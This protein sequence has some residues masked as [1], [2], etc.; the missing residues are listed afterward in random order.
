MYLLASEQLFVFCPSGQYISHE[1]LR[2]YRG[3][4]KKPFQQTSD[5]KGNSMD[6]RSGKSLLGITVI[7]GLSI[8]AGCAGLASRLNSSQ[9]LQSSAPA[10]SASTPLNVSLD[11]YGGREDIKCATVTPYFHLEKINS[12]WYFCDPLGNGLISMSVGNITPNGNPTTDCNGTNTYPIYIAKYGDTTSNWGWQTL[13]RMVSWGFNSA[14]QDSTGWVLP[15]ETC[16]TCAWPSGKQPIPLPY[17]TEAK[18]AEYASINQFGYLTSPIKDELAGT[19]NNYHSWRGAALFDVFDPALNTEWQNELLRTDES[20]QNIRNNYPYLLGVF[21]DDSDFFWGSGAGPDFSTGHTNANI[22]WV[23][24]ITSPVQTYIDYTQFGGKQLLYTTTQDYSKTLATN[25]TVI[26]SISNPC[27]LRDYLWQKYSG[28]ISLLNAAWSANYTTFDSTGTRVTGETIGTGNGSTLTF[29]H[30]LSHTPVSPYS[31]QIFVGG[32]AAIGDCPWFHAGCVNSTANTGSLGS[33]T[34]NYIVQSSSSINYSTGAVTLTFVTPPANGT[35]ITVSYIYGGWMAGG[36]GLMDEDGSHTTWVGT[37]P[38]CLEGADPNYPSYFACIGGGGNN[39]A[40]PNANQTL[41]AD[42][43]NWVP[44]MAAKYFK[45]MHDDVKAVSKVPYLGLDTIGS[46]SGPAY[47]KFLE[48]AAPY[49]D[50][51]FVSITSAAPSPSP[52]AFQSSYQYLT[53]YIGDIPLL[54]FNIIAAQSDSSYSCRSDAGDPNNMASQSI[55]GQMWY[56]TVSY[57]LTTPGFNGDTQFV[58]FDW[59]SWQDFQNLNQGLVSL[60]DNAYDGHEA[61]AGSVPCDTSY[62]SNA[63]CGG[64]IGNYGDAITPIR[65]A[66]QYWLLH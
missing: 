10:N 8:L 38:F 40:V 11:Q 12:H 46:W 43:D 26:C 56:N 33:P 13:K 27:S 3:V 34:A 63:V 24:L 5:K 62:A 66:N 39:E 28:S 15:W 64:E 35:A 2:H 21:T 19:N 47:S 16:S 50:G 7:A 30:A 36:T 1:Q 45:I 60:H 4:T 9:A 42:L 65:A 51:A 23:T 44:Q 52:A 37:N 55:R 6:L 49:V 25:P 59:W 22:A 53:R 48:G 32:T 58:G 41:G 31:V 14:G 29:T 18:P 54:N 17:I 57:L 61:V 20:T